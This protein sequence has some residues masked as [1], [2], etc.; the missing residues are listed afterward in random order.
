MKIPNTK[1]HGIPM[2]GYRNEAYRQ[3]DTPSPVT[4]F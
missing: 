3:T 1:L 2:S 4:R